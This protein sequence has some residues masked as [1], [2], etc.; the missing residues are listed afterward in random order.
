MRKNYG[1]VQIIIYEFLVL[2][3]PFPQFLLKMLNLL[4]KEVFSCPYCF[5]IVGYLTC[6]CTLN[7]RKTLI[8]ISRPE[9]RGRKKKRSQISL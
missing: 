7:Q 5:V 8:Q 2:S 1:N 6:C 9:F 3:F 4:Q